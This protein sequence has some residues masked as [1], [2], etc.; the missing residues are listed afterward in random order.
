MLKHL[1]LALFI[2]LAAPAKAENTQLSIADVTVHL[3]FEISGEF[4]TDITRIKNF[5]SWNFV[6]M[7]QGMP[8]ND[9]FNAF[10][11]K[12]K[13][14]SKNE[15]FAEGRQ[16]TVRVLRSENAEVL[17]EQNL[18]DIYVGPSGSATKPV[19][20][21]GHVCEPLDIVVAGGGKTVKKHLAFNCGE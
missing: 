11:I 16:A 14:G 2:L 9:R 21:T 20:V 6:P 4:S 15:V 8:D 7:G 13:L 5:S 3:F 19:L 12:V 10:L 17:V 18:Q 1:S